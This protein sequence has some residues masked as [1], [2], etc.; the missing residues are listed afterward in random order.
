MGSREV[1][2]YT[3]AY[4]KTAIIRDNTTLLSERIH[5]GETIDVVHFINKE[6][7]IFTQL[8]EG[9]QA[10]LTN[11]LYDNID[12]RLIL[13]EPVDKQVFATSGKR[14]IMIAQDPVAEIHQQSLATHIRIMLEKEGELYRLHYHP[15][16]AI[17]VNHVAI[18]EDT[19]L[20]PGDCFDI[21]GVEYTIGK[22]TIEVQDYPN[23][24][25]QVQLIQV[26]AESGL[27]QADVKYKRSPRIIYNEPNDSITIASPSNKRKASAQ[28]IIQLII[29]PLAMVTIT[30]IMSMV[31]NRGPYVLMA[32]A[33]SAVTICLSIYNYF[34]QKREIK[35]SNIQREV[36]YLNYLSNK[37]MQLKSKAEEQAYA[38]QYH[39]P[40]NQEILKMLEEYS[41]RMYEKS[42][43]HHDFLVVR[44][45]KAQIPSSFDIKFDEK[46]FSEE[47]DELI[48]EART[49]KQLYEQANELP[50]TITLANGAIG[51]VG[52]PHLL[53]EQVL[54]LL[55]Q[56][57]FFHSYH[58]VECI[59]VFAE[60]DYDYF[61]SLNYL[62]HINSKVIHARANV[63]SQK[64]RDQILSSIYQVMKQRDQVYS[65]NKTQGAALNF[66]PSFVLTILDMKQILDH[67]IMEF[68]SKD[69]TH[70][71]FHV[72]YVDRSMKNLP[73]HVK[74]VVEYKNHEH[75]IIVTEDQKLVNQ[76]IEL[77]H[78]EDTYA[79][80][81]ISRILAGYEHVLTLQSSIPEKVGFLEM[82]QV[83]DVTKLNILAK[84]KQN[85][86]GKTLAVPLGYRG[87]DDI[88][89]LNLHEKAHGPHGL[90]AGT[91]GSG[92][93]EIVQSY[94]LSLAIHFH[95][96]DVAFLLID[97]KGGGMANL[98]KDLPH[99]LGV[100]TNLDG[101]ASMRALI[102][103]K[104]EL[105][106]RQQL[107]S[108]QDVNHIDAYQKLFKEGKVK[109]PLPH[110]FMI[111][112]EFAE[113]KSEQPEFM[114]ELV[115]TARIGRSLGI[116]LIL[117]TQKPSG[118]VDDQI[119]SNSKF[120][121]CLKVQNESDS[122][123][124]LK[125]KDAAAI[126][127]P[128]RAYL[129]VGN[130]EIYELFQSAYSAAPYQSDKHVEEMK[131]NRIYEI[132][133][134]G[135]QE[136]LTQDLSKQTLA[137]KQ[138]EL[139]AVIGQIQ[140]EFTALG[141][142]KVASP[143][144]E[145][146]PE[147]I[148][149]SELEKDVTIQEHVNLDMV[150]G[151]SDEPQKQAQNN[152]VLSLNK[153]HVAVFGLSGFGKTTLLQ[154][155]IVS[156]VQKNTTKQLHMYALD[157][158]GALLPLKGLPHIADL[159]TLDEEDKIKKW[160]RLMNQ[161]IAER[162]RLFKQH[163]VADVETYEQLTN[164]QIER[165]TI[166][167]DNY[168]VVK[169]A[170][171]QEPFDALLLQLTR[172]G[173]ALGMHVI[174][175]ASRH[176]AIRYNMISNLKTQVSFFVLDK[177]DYTS[178][179][180]R[181]QIEPEELPGRGIIK[182]EEPT[183]FQAA[184][185]VEGIDAAERVENLRKFAQTM[186]ETYKGEEL[187]GIAIV[188]EQLTLDYFL[189]LN[190]VQQVLHKPNTLTVG[191][192]LESVDPVVINLEAGHVCVGLKNDDIEAMIQTIYETRNET[193]DMY[194]L[195]ND[196][197]NFIT[198]QDIVTYSADEA[199]TI[200]TLRHIFITRN[201]RKQ[202]LEEW[203]QNKE[204]KNLQTILEKDKAKL[205][206]VYKTEH[207]EERLKDDLKIEQTMELVETGAKY[208]IYFI[209]LQDTNN[210]SKT[211]G[212]FRKI[213]NQAPTAIYGGRV[214]DIDWNVT[215]KT[216]NE[217]EVLNKEANFISNGRFNK[218]KMI[219]RRD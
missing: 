162:K 21:L 43:L 59:N 14:L 78:V 34:K 136:L 163:G 102:S 94:I 81:K 68:L 217:P 125:T 11:H 185:P 77:D 113:L 31:M 191:L 23:S 73:E 112:D 53:R 41:S 128:G 32:V 60:E 85:E 167:I 36:V 200:E 203:I 151:L 84:W 42:S 202:Q 190:S 199:S 106:R 140:K 79:F 179:V 51:L 8:K 165:I 75:A 186:K 62:P 130:N 117:A 97:Y 187:E 114:K 206:F 90:V 46:E 87:P 37:L 198:L 142:E 70:L 126:T 103:I 166:M 196:S 155:M 7:Q 120:K 108:E 213:A 124:M 50:K 123:E 80:E 158:A 12:Y 173:I 153:G 214:N 33:T 184:L 28:S 52:H 181:T 39:Y 143:W 61:S 88:V 150:V 4:K 64:T 134:L 139:E 192:D 48:D 216:Y 27:K 209:L 122:N 99:L 146:L 18:Q 9:V 171:F 156:L 176:G 55:T 2:I 17:Y 92:K 118:V 135:Q 172:E 119:W 183:L 218:F 194:F 189:N 74:T 16:Q 115:S 15:K 169:E 35:E 141:I 152:L 182:L 19:L 89:Y 10:L 144:L 6:Q 188:P 197:R 95:P 91:T 208:G 71:G 147:S 22:A 154:T 204:T 26:E 83:D 127:L 101:A 30:I 195:D 201:E 121:L 133:N 96:Q 57:A 56:I 40:T 131:D 5:V 86:P 170:S 3:P 65:Q 54:L 58:D 132:N 109:E 145:P 104:A 210:F 219:E 24:I 105:L 205:V 63:Y 193:M 72:I 29:P 20:Y 129:Q 44:L 138:T 180:G 168:D 13:L 178:V 159:I 49:M 76:T 66:E 161:K 111:S 93:S 137:S 215:Q 148:E 160:G 164:Q 45:G 25:Q 157:F 212:T 38:L 100:I 177:S 211:R 175:S 69:V 107:F 47:K 98:F 67:S 1:A 149:L 174:I 207:L 110:L 116:H 82:L